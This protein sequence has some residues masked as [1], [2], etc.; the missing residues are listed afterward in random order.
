MQSLAGGFVT[1]LVKLL[2]KT[3]YWSVNTFTYE[4]Y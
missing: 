2:I 1:R 4:K 3:T